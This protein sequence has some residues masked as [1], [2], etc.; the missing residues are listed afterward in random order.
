M[1]V[2]STRGGDVL[3]YDRVTV[4]RP[5]K[6]VNSIEDVDSALLG[7]VQNDPALDGVT[8]SLLA[9]GLTD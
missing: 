4:T 8:E 2:P 9:S 6:R 3:S 1:L 5:R 7:S